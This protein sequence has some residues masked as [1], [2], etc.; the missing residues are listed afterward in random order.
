VALNYPIRSVVD[1]AA[2]SDLAKVNGDLGRVA[3]LLK[4]WLADKH[5][6]GV[7]AADVEAVMREFREL[8]REVGEIMSKIVYERN[9]KRTLE[10][11][12]DIFIWCF[13]QGFD[14]GALAKNNFIP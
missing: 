8:Q 7:R 3:G 4:L 1:L 2:V 6:R 14:V 13:I 10:G 5:G 9:R 12:S 11:V